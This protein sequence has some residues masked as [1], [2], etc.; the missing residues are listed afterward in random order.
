VNPVASVV[1]PAHDEE[2]R[3]ETTL[4]SLV[5][6]VAHGELEVVVVCNG[7]T[8]ATATVARSVAGVEV[9]EIAEASKIAALRV[10]DE[11]TR[12]FPRIYLDAD[13][14]LS[15]RAAVALARAL[16]GDQ[17][18]AARR[19]SPGGLSGGSNAVRPI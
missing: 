10:G 19:R 11:R 13:V 12:T 16:A 2:E 1:I 14:E 8:D 15:G 7:C 5:R 4:R 18:R 9:V 3:I 6:G 17:P